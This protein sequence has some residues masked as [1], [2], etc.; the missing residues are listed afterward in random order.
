MINVSSAVYLSDWKLYFGIS[1]DVLIHIYWSHPSGEILSVIFLGAIK[2]SLHI[3]LLRVIIIL[4]LIFKMEVRSD[5]IKSCIF[6]KYEI[7][8]T[9]PKTRTINILRRFWSKTLTGY[10]RHLYCE[11]IDE[12]NK[13]KEMNPMKQNQWNKTYLLIIYIWDCNRLV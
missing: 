13:Y 1:R 8:S 7:Y 3:D 4:V 11:R 2:V 6:K 12:A 9:Q 10:P 5:Y